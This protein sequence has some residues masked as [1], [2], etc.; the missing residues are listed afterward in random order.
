MRTLVI[1][2]GRVGD[3]IQTTPLLQDLVRDSRNSTEVLLVAPNENAVAG[4]QGI[5]RIRTVSPDARLLDE[6]IATQ[7]A[8]GE[9]PNKASEFLA[10]LCL[11]QYDRIINAS[12]A[13]LGCWL[14][15][16][17]PC[18]QREGGVIGDSRECLYEGVAHTYRVALLGF[19]ERNWFN[20]VDLL[21]CSAENRMNPQNGVR[22][23]VSTAPGL[24]FPIPPGRKVAL[25]VGAS[26]APRRWPPEHFAALAEGLA[27]SGFVPILVGAPSER[28]LAAQVQALCRC[29]VPS[30]METPIPEMARLLSLVDLLVS[31]D[32][33]AVH[34]AAAV[35][36]RVLSLSG[37][38]V[39]FAETAPWSDGN[40]ILQ[41]RP[42]APMSQLE[43]GIVLHA[44]LNL[45]GLA[46]ESGL[47]REL[48][49]GQQ[50]AWTTNFLPPEA[51][52]L[53]GITYW[54]VH[55][56]RTSVEDVFTRT[57]RHVFAGHFCGGCG[58][59]SIAY[60]K[61]KLHM[62][63]EALSTEMCQERKSLQI[64]SRGIVQALQQMSIVAENCR[65]LSQR[66]DREAG[67]AITQLAPLL[68]ESM[69]L[70]L[71]RAAESDAR[72]FQPVVQFLDWRLRMMPQLP[73]IE[74]F[75]YHASEYR[76]AA[77]MLERC[78]SLLENALPPL[79][80]D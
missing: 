6:Q 2:F 71:K 66:K 46:D 17:I 22:P 77:V 11:P 57:L 48:A 14:A 37:S 1:Q 35:G 65:E 49:R 51:D 12:H 26:E 20:L 63:R 33:G 38:S 43:P 73:P 53:G 10:G 47:R 75:A 61:E 34:I 39:Y 5:S 55:P 62:G 79:P 64:T 70:L 24:S 78:W 21:R 15:G 13:A 74:T 44:A 32:T 45:L 52:A 68:V 27:A 80:P 67:N 19:R 40:L 72:A 56:H 18:V 29:P 3:V 59:T 7:F 36:T 25:N 9:I 28:D 58:S 31:V 54:H 41:G 23:F 60:L 16:H 42:G 50:E 4:L 8:A 69:K 76:N 30:Y